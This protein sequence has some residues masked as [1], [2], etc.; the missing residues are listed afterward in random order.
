MAQVPCA[1]RLEKRAGVH[2]VGDGPDGEHLYQATV[3]AVEP[4]GTEARHHGGAV[5]VHHGANVIA[6]LYG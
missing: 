6:G 3:D 1:A 4:V 2:H 5:G